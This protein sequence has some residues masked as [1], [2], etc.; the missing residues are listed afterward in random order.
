MLCELLLSLF[1]YFIISGEASKR[2]YVLFFVITL[3]GLS[4][5]SKTCLVLI[6]LIYLSVFIGLVIQKPGKTMVVA[7]VLAGVAIIVCVLNLGV[8]QAYYNRFVGGFSNCKTFADFMNIIT[9]LRYDLWVEYLSYLAR[10]P[11]AIIF[12]KGVGAAPLSSYSAHNAFI[13]MIYEIGLVGAGLLVFAIVM[14]I[15]EFKHN[16]QTKIHKA[17]CV[18]LLVLFLIFMVEDVVFFLF[19]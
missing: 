8:V 10:H 4:T 6:V 2:D 17:I 16:S 14:M 5:F 11:L 19:F 3:L 1:A 15:K 13:S 7:S 18:P 9:T 12:G